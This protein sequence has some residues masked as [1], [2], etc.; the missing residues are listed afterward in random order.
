[1]CVCVCL[2][3][4]HLLSSNLVH[5]NPAILLSS[6]EG[7]HENSP[8]SCHH[9]LAACMPGPSQGP[10]AMLLRG[11]HTGSLNAGIIA[12]HHLCKT[13]GVLQVAHRLLLMQSTGRCSACRRQASLWWSPWAM[14]QSQAAIIFQV[15]FSPTST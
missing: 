11:I 13:S 6:T 10:R 1:M 7:N 5:P 2:P 9:S 14:W 4:L 15:M 12:I 8:A 3:G